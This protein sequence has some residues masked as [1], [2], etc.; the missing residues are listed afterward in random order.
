MR[1]PALSREEKGRLIAEL[2]NQIV[3]LDQ[4]TLEI[5]DTPILTGLQIYHNFVRPHES[6]KGK[7]PAEAAGIEA[8]GEKVD[9]TD[10]KCNPKKN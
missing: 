8:K 4:R 5:P 6:L 1:T 3:R 2:P 10:T 7:T 9:N